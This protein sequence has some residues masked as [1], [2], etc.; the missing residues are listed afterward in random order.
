MKT[1]PLSPKQVRFAIDLLT[2]HIGSGRL[3][4]ALRRPLT[5]SD[6]AQAAAWAIKWK[7]YRS[8]V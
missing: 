2:K 6:S 5:D 3:E 4:L 8:V 7:R 1:F